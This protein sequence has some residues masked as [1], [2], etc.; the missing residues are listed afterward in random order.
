MQDPKSCVLPLD[1]A[2]INRVRSAGRNHGYRC[3]TY[4]MIVKRHSGG[5]CPQAKQ[6]NEQNSESTFI[7]ATA[8]KKAKDR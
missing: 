3:T 6:A 7:E 5:V 4:A 1:D 8:D 2:P